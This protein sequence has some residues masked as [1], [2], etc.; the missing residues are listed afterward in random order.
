[1][2]SPLIKI[3]T[4]SHIFRLDILKGTATSLNEV[5]LDFIILRG[6]KPPIRGTKPRRSP[7]SLLYGSP[8]R[9]GK[10]P[11]QDAEA[12]TRIFHVSSRARLR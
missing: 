10:T 11:L 9:A 2:P 6:T 4:S 8:S 1:M 5:I 3:F 7:P 12:K